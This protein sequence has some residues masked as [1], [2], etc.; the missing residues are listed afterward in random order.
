M[1]VKEFMFCLGTFWSKKCVALILLANAEGSRLSYFSKYVY[2]KKVSYLFYCRFVEI[3]APTDF[4][5]VPK[6]QNIDGLGPL[7]F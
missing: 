1:G 2:Q 5:F 3:R 4:L 6:G 7:R